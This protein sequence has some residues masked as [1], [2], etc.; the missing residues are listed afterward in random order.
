LKTLAEFKQ[1]IQEKWNIFNEMI[2]N[3]IYTEKERDAWYQENILPLLCEKFRTVDHAKLKK[4]YQAIVLSVGESYQPLVLSICAVQPEK[5]Y[6]LHTEKTE[7]NIDTIVDVLKLRPRQY[8][9]ELVDPVDPTAIYQSIKR[10]L[11]QFDP[12]SIA[13]DF[14]GGTKSMSAGMAM[15]AGL[16]GADLI[17]ISSKWISSIRKPEAGTEELTLVPN[18]YEVFGDVEMKQAE[19]LWAQGEYNAAAEIFGSLSKRLPEHAYFQVL[20]KL[21]RA[22]DAW[23]VLKLGEARDH[24]GFVLTEGRSILWRMRANCLKD[25]EF[26]LIEQQYEIA[27]ML[28]D[29]VGGQTIEPSVL[30]DYESMKH[31]ILLLYSIGI[32]YERRKKWGLAAL[33][34]YRTIEM[35]FQHRIALHGILTDSPDYSQI[36]KTDEELIDKVNQILK[37][38]N[39]A[40]QCWNALPSQLAL[41]NTHVL[42][43]A[44]DDPIANTIN[45]SH[46]RGGL[47][48]R[49]YHYLTHGYLAIHEKNYSSINKIANLLVK[50]LLEVNG[51]DLD[52]LLPVYEGVKPDFSAIS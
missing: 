20:M 10:I 47:Y 52:S 46:I 29:H 32:N 24:F 42:L 38:H 40:E 5:I 23:S 50:K 19:E 13:I 15:A 22:Y 7:N 12:S 16:I 35:V 45:V 30:Q 4:K 31:L 41:S 8:Q 33:H 11:A 14:T 43:C 2:Q 49:N 51:E 17:Y 26:S 34:M 18:P 9:K 36:S 3:P 48:T 44:L 28:A 27:R 21:A 37:K 25:R 1:Q 6:F 39:A